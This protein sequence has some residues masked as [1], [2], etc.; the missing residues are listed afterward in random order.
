MTLATA[1]H[2]EEW[3]AIPKDDRPADLRPPIAAVLIYSESEVFRLQLEWPDGMTT[4]ALHGSL[5][6]AR[7]KADAFKRHIRETKGAR[8]KL[9]PGLR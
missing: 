9:R 2:R 3:V 1:R 5:T 7:R 4:F 8:W 6:A